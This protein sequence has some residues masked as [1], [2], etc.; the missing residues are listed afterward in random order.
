MRERSIRLSILLALLLVPGVSCSQAPGGA[1][2]P[3]QAMGNQSLQGDRIRQTWH[4]DGKVTDL[5][6][7]PVRGASVR[8]DPGLGLKFVKLLTSDVQGQFKAEYTMDTSTSTSLSLNVLV[9]REGFHPARKFVDFGSGDKTW[10]ID[11]VMRP[12]TDSGDDLPVETLISALAPQLRQNLENSASIAPSRKDFERGAAA[13]LDEHE[14]AKAIPS[15]NKVVKRYPECS[16]CRTLLGL[17]MLDAGDWDGAAS[18]FVEADKLIPSAGSAAA[19]PDKANSLLIIAELENWKGEYAKAAGFLMQAKDLDPSNALI[20]EE[21]GRTLVLQKNWEAADQYLAKAINAGASKEALLLRTR[22]LLE[23]G[24]PEAADAALKEYVGTASLKTF[25][26]PVRRLYEEVE[27]RLNLQSYSRVQ[28]VVNQPLASLIQAVPELQGLEPA[29]SEEELAPIL[30]RTGENVKAFFDSFENTASVEQIR[31]ERLAKD[32][33]VKD[34]QD[35]KFQYLLLARQEKWGL[36]LEEYRTNSHGDRTAPTG[37]E[38]GMMVTSGFASASLLFHPEYQAGATFRYLGKQALNGRPC[39]V[40]GF[41]QS[42]AKAQMVE[43]FNMDDESVLVLFQGLAWIDAAKF[44]I[45]RLRTDLLQPETKIR[46]KR[47]TTEIT[48]DP[49]QFK[50]IAAALWLPSEVAVTL[51]WAGKT[52]HNEHRY[53]DFRLF[54]TQI[55][56]K[57]HT[58]PGAAEQESSEPQTTVE[59]PGPKVTLV[60]KN[61]QADS[62][63][64][65]AIQR[66]Q[67]ELPQDRRLVFIL[68]SEAPPTFPR[69]EKIEVATADNSAS[70]VLS[71]ADG[72]LTLQ[73]PATVLAVFDPLKSFGPSALGPLHFRVV[74]AQGGNGEWQPLATV[75]RL[76]ALK[77]VRCPLS[78][79]KQCTLSGTNL[80]LI[81]SVASDEQF[82]HTVPVPVGFVD[83]VLNVPRPNGTVLYLKLRD[84]PSVVNMAVLPVLPDL[85]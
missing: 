76:P 6:G 68:K 33:K 2:M 82:T 32:G 45:V 74:T 78:L 62:S 12:D 66:N 26:V 56:E 21:L 34:S 64:A 70:I 59:P 27:A 22:A 84:D 7:Q 3:N 39:H 31:E 5:K 24:D 16:H 65:S 63:V 44:K 40:V 9:E 29:T 51:D 4:I 49:V 81:D 15:L 77:E 36:G 53:S 28:S 14:P 55:Q 19:N 79:D 43:R 17:A 72:S 80:F 71:L 52:Y 35:Q 10:E 58:A 25:P 48:Y 47:Q 54:N 60:T 57:I 85:Q 37:L 83:S 50:Q 38:S 20:L 75:V 42:P 11:V 30:K 67:D 8:V 41:A 46:L 69:D 13:F 73:D 1:S 61:I 18:Q 23:E